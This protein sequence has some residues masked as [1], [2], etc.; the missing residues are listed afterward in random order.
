MFKIII[1]WIIFLNSLSV[2]SQDSDEIKVNYRCYHYSIDT[3]NISIINARYE[4][5]SDKD[6]VLWI[7]SPKRNKKRKEPLKSYLLD[8]RGEISLLNFFSE[9]STIDSIT[10]VYVSFLKILKP[11]Q[12]FEINILI[13]CFVN[14]Q[15]I[16][17]YLKE[18]VFWTKESELEI[19]F[20]SSEHMDF[21]YKENQIIIPFEFLK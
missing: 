4:N 9:K 19:Y 17:E 1:G 3:N 7:D 2:F 20:K 5:I 6:I 15:T 11:K 18:S 8:I 14:D 13:K 21:F 12:T 16:K 10:G